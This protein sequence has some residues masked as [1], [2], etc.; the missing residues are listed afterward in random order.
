MLWMTT[1]N[2]LHP[3]SDFLKNFSGSDGRNRRES[4]AVIDIFDI[5]TI[6]SWMKK[7]MF[8]IDSI[9]SR[10]LF[11]VTQPK[12]KKIKIIFLP[13]TLKWPHSLRVHFF[14]FF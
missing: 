1:K 2:D 13:T 4:R 6:D 8:G 5:Y 3:F 7:K 10:A 9:V 12:Q 14:K 11:S